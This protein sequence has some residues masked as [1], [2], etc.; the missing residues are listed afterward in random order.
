MPRRTCCRTSSGWTARAL[1]ASFSPSW[2]STAD[3][4]HTALLPVA[5]RPVAF[6]ALVHAVRAG[7]RS[8][9]V[10]AIFRGTVVEAAI[11]ASTRVRSA[12]VWLDH[13]VL[14][15]AATRLVPASTVAPAAAL[16]ALLDESPPAILTP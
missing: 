5:G 4:A 13:A 16:A 9:G 1:R 14:A 12:A 7:S 6:R 10:P 2:T 11:D 15:T 8:V 3:D